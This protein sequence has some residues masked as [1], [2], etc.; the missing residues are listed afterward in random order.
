MVKRGAFVA[1]G[2]LAMSVLIAAPALAA[3]PG[4]RTCAPGETIV[5]GVFSTLLVNGTSCSVSQI[6]VESA[7]T[8]VLNPGAALIANSSTFNGTIDVTD[9]SL[10]LTGSTVRTVP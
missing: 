4:A 1:I 7:G 6:R 2:T 3:A 8:F 5:R 10:A 9:A